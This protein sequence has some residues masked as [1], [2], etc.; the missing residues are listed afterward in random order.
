MEKKTK[1]EI[2]SMSKQEL[3]EYIE[4]ITQTDICKDVEHCRFLIQTFLKKTT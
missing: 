2:L 3:L 4:A 1:E